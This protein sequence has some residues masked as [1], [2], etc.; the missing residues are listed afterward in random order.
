MGRDASAGAPAKSSPR[1]LT[2]I[3]CLDVL[4]RHAAVDAMP[5]RE[6]NT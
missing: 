5:D 4:P 2:L 1:L 3:K 6:S